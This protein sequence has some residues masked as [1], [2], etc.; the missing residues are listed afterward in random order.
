MTENRFAEGSSFCMPQ[1]LAEVSSA[2]TF[3][4]VGLLQKKSI[5]TDDRLDKEMSL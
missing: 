2:G 5:L 3:F 4:R 1:W